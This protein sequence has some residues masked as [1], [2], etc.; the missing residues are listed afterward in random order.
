MADRK[1][2]ERLAERGQVEIA[3]QPDCGRDVVERAVRFE[4]VDEPEPL[5]GERQGQ[6]HPS[7]FVG[8]ARNPG[9][10]RRDPGRCFCAEPVDGGSEAA[11]GR[12]LEKPPQRELDPERAADARH[13]LRGRE[14][15]PAERK[16]VVVPA[17]PGGAKQVRPDACEHFLRR[18]A[19]QDVA[20]L[21]GGRIRHGEPP[22]VDLA[23]GRERPR[24]DVDEDGRHHVA[25]Q[26]PCQRGA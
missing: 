25:R 17:D 10:G 12:R 11:H 19:R 8:L 15:V 1:R 21:G 14:R 16:E 13:E 5:L 20:F 4:L 23:V 9:D 2:V 18:G 22:P 3:G 6:S 24:I 7:L 26:P